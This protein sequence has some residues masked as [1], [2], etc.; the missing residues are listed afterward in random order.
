MEVVLRKILKYTTNMPV[1]VTPMDEI[2]GFSVRPGMF[3]SNGAIA[4]PV[5]VNFT[6]HTHHGTSCTLL[7]FHR[8]EDEP[9]AEIPFPE[10]YKIGDVYS[11]I[12]FDL[13]IR[14]F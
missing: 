3:D 5:G 6:V 2:N 4:L 12:V 10:S 14:E 8:G 1:S 9:Y 7:L 13:D 11:M